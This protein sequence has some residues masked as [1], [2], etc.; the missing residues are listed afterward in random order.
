MEY[1]KVMRQADLPTQQEAIFARDALMEIPEQYSFIVGQRML[2]QNTRRRTRIEPLP[3]PQIP[4]AAAAAAT[5]APQPTHH[6]NNP[7][8]GYAAPS[9]QPVHNPDGPPPAHHTLPPMPV[10]APMDDELPPPY[11]PDL[12]I[13]KGSKGDPPG[14]TDGVAEELE[15]LRE[16]VRALPWIVWVKLGAVEQGPS[17]RRGGR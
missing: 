1:N 8:G 7:Y 16:Q 17:W 12:D 4:D 5:T 14:A 6:A 15:N 10:A 2:G 13:G 11:S 3:G 9:Q